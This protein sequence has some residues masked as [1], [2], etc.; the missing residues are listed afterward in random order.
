MEESKI[1]Q[2]I[3]PDVLTKVLA[4]TNENRELLAPYMVSLTSAERKKTYKVADGTEA[5]VDKGISYQKQFPQFVPKQMDTKEMQN[6]YDLMTSLMPVVQL[7]AGLLSLMSDTKMS[8]GAGTLKQLLKYYNCVK[9]AAKENVPEAKDV[10]TDLS[11]RYK[12]R[13]KKGAEPPKEGADAKD[14]HVA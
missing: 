9:Q 5:F 13:K 12:K 8:A 6:D 2:I 1:L 14:V 3:P 11:K 10:Y 4:N 7:T